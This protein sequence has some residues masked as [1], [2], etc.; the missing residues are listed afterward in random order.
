VTLVFRRRTQTF[1]LTYLLIVCTFN[2][3]KVNM[4][5][6]LNS[7]LTHKTV[8]YCRPLYGT[9]CTNA[10]SNHTLHITYH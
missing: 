5:C 6:S 2:V 7:V 8:I 4:F 3:D 9:L 10:N 1:L